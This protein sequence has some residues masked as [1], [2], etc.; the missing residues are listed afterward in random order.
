MRLLRRSHPCL[1]SKVLT[2]ALY[3]ALNG[4]A[5]VL[6]VAL[7]LWCPAAMPKARFAHADETLPYLDSSHE[8]V[9]KLTEN[10]IANSSKLTTLDERIALINKRLEMISDLAFADL[11]VKTADL[12]TARAGLERDLEEEKILLGE[13]VLRLVLDVEGSGLL[14]SAFGSALLL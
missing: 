7:I 10:A 11:E 2:M 13:K 1:W 4:W 9:E 12:E 6:T 8:C 3:A 5:K 14:R